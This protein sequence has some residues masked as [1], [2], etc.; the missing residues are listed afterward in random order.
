M[1]PVLEGI[2]P[3]PSATSP[4]TVPLLGLA[5]QNGPLR[6]EIEAAIG[7]LLN[8]NRYILDPET[9]EFESA[10]AAYLGV[11]EA[12]GCANGTDVLILALLA[13]GIAPAS[14][15]PFNL[16][17]TRLEEAARCRSAHWGRSPGATVGR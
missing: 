15:R 16:D 8:C 4:R 7:R 14:A 11:P 17:P 13:L 2:E 3:R 12:I 5:P 6:S 1:T 9:G 10:I